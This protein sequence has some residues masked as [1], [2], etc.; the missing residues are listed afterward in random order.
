MSCP[1]SY[2]CNNRF[3]CPCI[4]C[5]QKRIKVGHNV[6]QKRKTEFHNEMVE[7]RLNQLNKEIDFNHRIVKKEKEIERKMEQIVF[8]KNDDSKCS[9]CF[10]ML[11]NSVLRPCNHNITCYGCAVK[12]DKCPVCRKDIKKKLKI[13][14]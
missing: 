11:K 5:V 14:N 9:I 8:A 3:N 12:L 2:V 6:L 7:R 10:Q 13:F 4:I 1:C